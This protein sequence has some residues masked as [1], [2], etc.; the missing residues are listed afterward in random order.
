MPD[1]QK[2]PVIVLLTSHWVT[3]AGVALVTLAGF[4]WLFALPANI[5]GNVSNPYIGLLT[6]I[7]I[8]I[9]FFVGLILIPIGITLGRRRAAEA[10]NPP[11]DRKAAW[12]RAGMFFTIMTMA[13]LVIG[14]Q[15]TYRA[16]EHMETTQFCGQSCHVMKPE[17][18]AHLLP[19]HQQVACAS[20]HVGP[21]ATGWLASKMAGTRQL[22]G[23]VLNNYPRPIESAMESNRLVASADTC[24]QCHA[25]G[26]VIGPRLRMH[27][28]FKDDEANTRSE[29]V[30][31]MMV[32]GGNAGGIHGAHMG[33]GV[34]IRYA[35][36][37]KKRQT[38]PWVE[39]S[40]GSATQTYLADGTTPDAA[41]ALPT[42]EMQCVDCHNRVGHA[43]ESPEH[44]IDR[45]LASS[46]IP[47]TLPFVKKT[48]IELLKA[49]YSSDDDAAQ[50]I[51][52]GLTAFYQQKYSDIWAKRANDVQLAGQ[53]L[54][55]IYRDNVFPDLKVTWTTYPNNLGHMDDPGCFR[56]HDG[57]HSTAG[58]KTLT[59]D[60]S[61]CHQMLAVDETDPAILKTLGLG[62]TLS[63]AAKQ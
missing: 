51:P 48:G 1:P 33:Q 59:Q 28:S 35:A 31:M 27:S 15:L 24:E 5:R 39:Y 46:Q 4:S 62:D 63:S 50:R 57:G 25:R 8:P 20:C 19:P 43:F 42:F 12:R 17:F 21:G 9:V 56:C 23:V 54:L 40:N 60:C 6:F 16:V 49:S 22:I 52:S 13:N 38:I 3:M 14:S 53:A 58:K 30:L 55:A 61:T 26:K 47:V 10:L 2:Q 7:A 41:R 44:A 34:H 11:V 37:D 45:A 29:T 32:G 36:S 18:T